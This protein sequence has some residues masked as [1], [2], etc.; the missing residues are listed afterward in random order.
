MDRKNLSLALVTVMLMSTSFI[1]GCTDPFIPRIGCT[2]CGCSYSGTALQP[3]QSA[4]LTITGA[5]IPHASDFA[6]T[7][8]RIS[9]VRPD[10]ELSVSS[11]QP[12]T[13][14][15]PERILYDFSFRG[16]TDVSPR[17]KVP[18]R[19]WTNYTIALVAESS[20]PYIKSRTFFNGTNDIKVRLWNDQGGEVLNM[21]VDPPILG[22]T[23]DHTER[24]HNILRVNTT[25]WAFDITVNNG[26]I[27]K[28]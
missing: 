19:V 18:E 13:N 27:C 3:E 28:D 22:I 12:A 9:L 26:A 8:F 24:G 23:V 5:D 15:T 17:F 11:V 25:E 10:Y 16:P 1:A 7:N 21:T 4:Q 2:D 14:T 20:D 6:K